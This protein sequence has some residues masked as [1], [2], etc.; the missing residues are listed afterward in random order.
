MQAVIKAYL[1]RPKSQILRIMLR[2]SINLRSKEQI[3]LKN[4]KP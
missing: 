1:S 2:L 3:G 4:A